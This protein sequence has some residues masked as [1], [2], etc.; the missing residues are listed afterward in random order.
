MANPN[1]A[2][3]TG[4][5]NRW[6][7]LRY[8]RRKNKVASTPDHVGNLQN[9]EVKKKDWWKSI[10]YILYFCS[11]VMG[12]VLLVRSFLIYKIAFE[13]WGLFTQQNAC[14]PL[15]GVWLIGQNLSWLCDVVT[16]TATAIAPY[17]A[18]L[19]LTILQS[20]ATFLIFSPGAI[21][22]MVEQLRRNNTRRDKL[23]AYTTDDAETARLVKRHA[24]VQEQNL[25]TLLVFS[26]LA[27]I[28][29][30]FIVWTARDG[31]AEIID[32]L[33][34][35]LAFDALVAFVLI[36]RNLFKAKPHKNAKRWQEA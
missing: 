33:V 4:K 35:S 32:I 16:S 21:A 31:Q 8:I 20:I 6:N 29:E 19:G 13:K 15:G 10:R 34:D 1:T 27:F 9:S 17:A 23:D 22:G 28:A 26:V 14:E 24:K 12:V 7:P 25:R 11:G 30:A 36:L 5:K 18:L 2:S 3:D